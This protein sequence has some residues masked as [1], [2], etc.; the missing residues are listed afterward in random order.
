M[1]KWLVGAGLALVLTSCGAHDDFPGYIWYPD[2]FTSRA[3][4]PLD[5]APFPPDS[6]VRFLPPEG[7]IPYS[8]EP[9]DSHGYY[10]YPYPN[11]LEGYEQAKNLVNPLPATE[12]VIAQ[13]KELFQIYCAPCHGRSGKGNG[14][15]VE[16]GGFPPPPSYFQPRLYALSDGQMF[17]SITYGKNLMGSFRYQLTP[18][19]R[20]MVI[21][22]IRHLQK[23]QLAKE[24]KTLADYQQ[25]E[26]STSAQNQ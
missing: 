5:E 2:M 19:E 12:E 1:K 9:I 11:T 24:G 14:P 16:I 26:S 13:G 17:H 8:S 21:H 3:W 22:Y 6:A 4:E 15:V 20:W 18:K 7:V 10:R 23:Q 25:P